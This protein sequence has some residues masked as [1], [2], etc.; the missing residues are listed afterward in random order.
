[1]I[2]VRM[3]VPI[4]CWR[5]GMAR[6]Y[7]ET[8]ELPPP[9]TCYGALLSFVGE[10]DRQRHRGCRVTAGVVS[11]EQATSVVLRS[12]WRVK[13]VGASLGNDKNARPDFQQLRLRNDLIIWLDSSEEEAQ[14]TLENRVLAAFTDPEGIVRF[15]GLSLGE[16]THLVNDLWLL[17]DSRPPA[18]CRAFVLDSAGTV[19]MPTWVDHVGSAGTRF[20]VGEFTE[21]R[22]PP[23]VSALS[24][25]G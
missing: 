8:Y 9:A 16:S 12:L 11:A 20:A 21:L 14:P 7:L 18:P 13:D 4:A 3:T 24:S 6:E 10:E 5:V 22:E 19:T 17:V 1:V 25:I 23:P 2:A 15:G